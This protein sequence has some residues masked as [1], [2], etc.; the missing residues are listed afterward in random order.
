MELPAAVTCA[1]CGSEPAK[2]VSIRRHVGMLILQTF[3]K[4]RQ[5]VCRS[6]GLKLLKSFTLKTLWQGWWGYIS[7]FFNWFVLVA[8]LAAFLQLRG[9]GQPRPAVAEGATSDRWQS[10]FD[11]VEQPD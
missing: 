5:P 3:V 8:N 11:G 9:L 1:F 7:F 10:A 2:V 6:C 4:V